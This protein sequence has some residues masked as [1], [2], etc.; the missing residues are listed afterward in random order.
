V[1]ALEGLGATFVAEVLLRAQAVVHVELASE[2]G[3]ERRVRV[4]NGAPADR[5]EPAA[6]A[7]KWVAVDALRFRT[8]ELHAL[9][10]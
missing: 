4:R 6:T 7:R 8:S 5:V 1:P 10:R 3:L 2:H 9:R